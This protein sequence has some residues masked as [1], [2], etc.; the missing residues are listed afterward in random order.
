MIRDLRPAAVMAV[1]VAGLLAAAMLGPVAAAC[2]GLA[3]AA[4]GMAPPLRRRVA[5][6]P[7]GATTVVVVLALGAAALAGVSAQEL[8]VGL[9][10]WLQVHRRWVRQGEGDDRVSV[11]L[12]GMMLLVAAGRVEDPFLAAPVVAWWVALPLALSTGAVRAR[13]GL[14]LIGAVV[15]CAA[16]AFVVAPR[17]RSGEPGAGELTGFA[18]RVELGAMDE[19]LD[20]PSVVFRAAMHPLPEGPVYW[21]G[22][23]LDTFDGR[24]WSSSE[25]PVPVDVV[26]P[27]LLP[28]RSV[29]ID[30]R[31]EEEGTV[32]FTAGRVVDLDLEQGTL[33]GDGQGG[34]RSSAEAARYRVVAVPPFHPGELDPERQREADGALLR[35]ATALPEGYERVREL[36]ASLAGDGPAEEQVTRLAEHLASTYTY[37][38]RPGGRGLDAPLQDFLFETRAGHCEYFSAALAVLA[39]SRGLPARVVNGFV[40]GELDPETGW[41]TVRRYHAHSWTEVYLDGWVGFDATPGPAASVAPPSLPWY[42]PVVRG[43]RESW[44]ATVDYDRGDQTE[45]LWSVSRRV[46]GLLPSAR[47]TAVPWRGL[48]VV[49]ALG[50][51]GVLV[52][53]LVAR[54]VAR[55]L[56]D[57]PVTPSGGPVARA[58]DRARRHLASRG[59]SAPSAMPPVEAARH[60][61][62]EHPGEAAEAMVDLAWLYYEVRLGGSDPRA[63]A[64]RARELAERVC[65]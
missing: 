55:G 61:A 33:L 34:W 18:P 3:V 41:W 27:R 60:I 28:P 26:G 42:E 56:L 8:L 38:R 1:V 7:L 49:A 13:A 2:G 9:L 50:V 54:R 64:P 10:A 36:A 30:V 58:H 24:R 19:L 29:V 23:A 39:R 14:A 11:L 17:G 35:R 31:P 44:Q 6:W 45:A 20:D 40:G 63:V 48:L 15:L 46:D 43:V 22:V 59:M 51:L 52:A 32:L 12:S 25:Q 53:R 21:R 16:G 4:C 37:S 47:P 62:R 5:G 65:R 57:A